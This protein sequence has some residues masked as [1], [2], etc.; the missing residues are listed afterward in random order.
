[1]VGGS[2]ERLNALL[3]LRHFNCSCEIFFSLSPLPTPQCIARNSNAI[4]IPDFLF[5]FLF[6]CE[7]LFFSCV[8]F[9]CHLWFINWIRKKNRLW[10][11]YSKCL[12]FF[13]FEKTWKSDLLKLGQFVVDKGTLYI[14][15]VVACRSCKKIKFSNKMILIGCTI[16]WKMI[17]EWIHSTKL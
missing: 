1:M 14:S 3:D 4:S 12:T 5:D 7:K 10:F 13:L 2:Q 15:W 11:W 9:V 16:C 8:W 17:Y 6:L